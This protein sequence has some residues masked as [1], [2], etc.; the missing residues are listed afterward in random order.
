MEPIPTFW[1]EPTGFA[2][3]SLRRFT[4]GSCVTGERVGTD[5]DDV[6]HEPC[7]TQPVSESGYQT[8]HGSA[9]V[10]VYERWPIEWDEDKPGTLALVDPRRFADSPSW[11]ESCESCGVPF[12]D[13]VRTSIVHSQANQDV[14]YK[15]DGMFEG[16]I[17]EMPAGAMWDGAWLR[18][19]D[20]CG[21]DGIALHVKLPPAKAWDYWCVDCPSSKGGRWTREGDPRQANVTARPSILTPYFHG[22]LTAGAII[23]C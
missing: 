19:T 13:E 8:G 14:V 11:P 23:E 18:D 5:S 2:V 22:F 20:W 12:T 15:A 6:F 17:E 21:A 9:S 10:V 4:F 3:L 16:T 7:L 1:C